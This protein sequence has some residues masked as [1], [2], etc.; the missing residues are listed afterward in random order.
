MR[1]RKGRTVAF[2][3]QIQRREQFGDLVSAA[4]EGDAAAQ[5]SVSAVVGWLDQFAAGREAD[6]FSC[7]SPLRRTPGGLL[8]MLPTRGGRGVAGGLCALCLAQPGP[9]LIGG[10]MATIRKSM[11]SAQLR[12]APIRGGNA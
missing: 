1:G 4:I 11:P 6:C 5:S 9:V 12:C 2:E 7:G 10:V 3:L 8:L